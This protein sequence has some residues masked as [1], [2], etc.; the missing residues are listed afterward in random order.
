MPDPP[1][2]QGRPNGPPHGR[3]REPFA[4]GDGP[5]PS[6]RPGQRPSLVARGLAP[7]L[8]WWFSP[9]PALRL[10]RLRMALGAFAT[11]YL[12][13]RVPSLVATTTMSASA[14][15]PIGPLWWLEHPVAPAI[16]YLVILGTAACGF[17][18]SAG[19]RFRATAPAFALGCAFLF[20]Y[21]SSW[22]M[23][24]H[25]DN[26]LLLHVC[27]LALSPAADTASLDAK[28]HRARERRSQISHGYYGWPV[29]LTGTVTVVTYVVAGYAKLEHVGWQW[30]VG[31]VLRQQI[32]Y[33]NVRKLLAGAMHAPWGLQ[34]IDQ[35]WLMAVFATGTLVV[36]LGAP[37]ALLGRR[38]GYAWCI[39]AW[40]FHI[41]VLALMAILF[42]YPVL[43]FAYLSFFPLERWP[44]RSA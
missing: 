10:A 39:C 36:E 31:D 2:E 23:V 25:T 20:T 28:R 22:S 40:G 42:A 6:R 12:L 38:L 43:G 27:V 11:I 41:G 5:S 13:V 4:G 8:A 35:A 34:V 15:E 44:R 14:F 17:G 29:Q 33:D 19:W 16:V 7:V 24:F 21:R 26:L 37:V 3:Q 1:L 9:F 18:F 30:C 32:A